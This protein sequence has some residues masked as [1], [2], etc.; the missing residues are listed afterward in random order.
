MSVSDYPY[1]YISGGKIEFIRKIPNAVLSVRKTK[2]KYRKC[3]IFD[4]ILTNPQVPIEGHHNTNAAHHVSKEAIITQRRWSYVFK[5]K[6][7]D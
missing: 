5:E 1:T 6:M 3:S 4:P 2:K 7:Q